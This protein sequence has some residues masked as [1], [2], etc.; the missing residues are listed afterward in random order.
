[1]QSNNIICVYHPIFTNTCTNTCISTFDWTYLRKICNH[2]SET[3]IYLAGC[4]VVKPVPLPLQSNKSGD[5]IN[6]RV[7]MSYIG[8]A[9]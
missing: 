1:M 2:I 3:Q 8:N 7:H 6:I 4:S 5:E 9:T